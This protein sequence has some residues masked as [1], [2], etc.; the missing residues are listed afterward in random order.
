MIKDLIF[1]VGMNNGEDTAHYLSSGY[2][3]VAVEANPQLCDAV[4]KRFS[5]QVESNRLFIEWVA[6]APCAGTVTFWIN[7]NHRE[8][9]ACEREIASRGVQKCTTV[10]ASSVLFVLTLEIRCSILFED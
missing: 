5:K 3:V 6:I 8:F 1:D 9:S 10:S 2:R 4:A 7:E